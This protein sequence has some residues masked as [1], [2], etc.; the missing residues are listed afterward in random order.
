MRAVKFL[1]DYIGQR[2]G[3]PDEDAL[4]AIA[5]CL[6]QADNIA[7]NN[8]FFQDSVKFY[9]AHNAKLEQTRPGEK[10]WGIEW[11][12]AAEAERKINRMKAEEAKLAAIDRRL[13]DAQRRFNAAS[14]NYENARKRRN[15]LRAGTV[16]LAAL[17]REARNAA[18]ALEGVR[19]EYDEQWKKVPRPQFPTEVALV[20][21]DLLPD[22]A[23]ASAAPV[24][25][26]AAPV[27][28]PAAPP[29]GPGRVAARPPEE[30][31]V[32]PTFTPPPAAPGPQRPR[33]T[34][35]AA[36][37]PVAPDLLVTSAA[38]VDGATLIR[39]QGPDG[40]PFEAAVVDKDDASGLALLKTKDG[41]RFAYLAVADTFA[42][43][44]VQC[45]SF[46]AVNLFD[47]VA[48]AFPGSAL[49]PASLPAGQEKWAVKLSRHPRL[50]GSPLV[51]NGKVV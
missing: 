45:V 7:R 49:N 39:L 10:R 27:A 46:P 26:G 21:M 18:S 6:S 23:V 2:P 42:G 25:P 13:G 34:Q 40:I 33:T 51:V 8:K 16:N 30:V 24:G 3:T 36:A 4:N 43:G 44:P 12:P 37:F 47:P 48:E 20:P 28:P 50:G 15:A 38:A 11:L 9:E 35:Y 31:A 22:T 19:K 14:S 29:V 1:R 41:K 17:E 32:V 5:T